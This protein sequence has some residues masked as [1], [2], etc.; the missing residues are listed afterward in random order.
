MPFSEELGMQ[1]YDPREG[2][3]V[4][5]RMGAAFSSGF[6]NAKD[7]ALDERRLKVA[8]DE[9]ARKAASTF[10]RQLGLK[11]WQE[12]TQAL[13]E[14]GVEPDLARKN[15]F[16]QAA[17][18][19]FGET[20]QGLAILQRMEASEE[21]Q[22]VRRR[23]Q[24]MLDDRIRDLQATR[25]QL[26]GT[27]QEINLLKTTLEAERESG[28]NRRM[29][30]AETGRDRRADASLR[31]RASSDEKL[32]EIDNELADRRKKLASVIQSPRLNPFSKEKDVRAAITELE[33]ARTA[34]LAELG[35]GSKTAPATEPTAA[36]SEPKPDAQGAE[37]R[38]GTV[39]EQG[40]KRYRYQGGPVN[41]S[42]SYVEVK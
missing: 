39:V 6:E 30:E 42:A 22:E 15:A 1:V 28:R 31:L 17:P 40:G 13:I 37:L 23:G 10:R 7:R 35:I 32:Q 36:T 8:E 2:Q 3:A 9:V 27:Q 18:L 19:L 34:R 14:S 4:G 29:D 16:F 25:N 5:A 38:L 41:D 33:K 12:D 21:A 20:D 26:T 24:D 11:Q